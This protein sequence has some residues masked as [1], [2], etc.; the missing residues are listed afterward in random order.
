[1]AQARVRRM[2]PEAA[3]DKD[4]EVR[5]R[6]ELLRKACRL[7]L[8]E[9]A[10]KVS[11]RRGLK[12]QAWKYMA[13]LRILAKHRFFVILVLI[14]KVAAVVSGERARIA[15][16]RIQVGRGKFFNVECVNFKAA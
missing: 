6:R 15:M 14:A 4:D 1:M 11:D 13:T 7:P 10:L 16:T 9:L 8:A 12:K 5:E 2:P 3:F